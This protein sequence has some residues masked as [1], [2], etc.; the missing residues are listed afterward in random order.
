MAKVDV[1]GRIFQG[2]N[3]S[4][5][6]FVIWMIPMTQILRK[7]ESRYTLKNREKLNHLLFTNDLMIFAKSDREVNGLVSTLQILSNNIAMELG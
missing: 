5:L 2:D 3:L 6:L 4:P 7:V 1:R